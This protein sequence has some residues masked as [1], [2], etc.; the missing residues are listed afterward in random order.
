MALNQ[1]QFA[2]TPIQ[3]MVD[4]QGFGSNVISVAV[5]DNQV[6]PLVA[7]QP[8]K[9]ENSAGG[10]P[11]VVALTANTDIP[12]GF[13]GYNLKD[14]NYPADARAEM[15]MSGSVMYM[16]AGAAIARWANVEI[17]YVN[18]RVITSAGVN[19]VAGFAFDKAAALGDLIR[20]YIVNPQL[21]GSSTIAQISGL[22]AALNA[23]QAPVLPY[24]AATAIAT[25]GNGTLTAAGI[26]GKLITRTGP[27]GA[28]TDTLDTAVNIVAALNTYVA[29]SSFELKIK[30]NSLY[31]QTI[32]TAAGITLTGSVIIPPQSVGTYLVTIT[33][34]TAVAVAHIA[35]TDK[36]NLPAAQ[37][38][39]GTTTTTFAAGQLE[40]ADY[41]VYTNTQATPGSIATR[42]ATQM[43]AG[44]PNAYDGQAYILRVIN[45]QGTGT[46]TMTAGTD[47]TLTGTATIA[48]NTWRDYV[49]TITSVASHTLTIQNAGTGTFS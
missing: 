38:N 6:L 18:N 36:V 14:I 24:E 29:G 12:A 48:I 44:I 41:V 19:P 1:N 42:T 10:V 3:G 15:A 31:N 32:Q 25:A 21:T 49:V 13:I 22:Q 23:V 33:S 46:L 27:S 2:Q 5:S 35:T 47:V 40:G 20:V 39:T 37:F 16:T 34:P 9:I 45:G 17:D 8:V 28:F 26:V 11:K 43:I 30:N 7:G 4:L